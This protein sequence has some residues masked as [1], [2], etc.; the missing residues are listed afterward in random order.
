MKKIQTRIQNKRD[1]EINWLAASTF[2]PLAGELIIYSKEVDANGNILKTKR[3]DT[4]ISVVPSSGAHAR[5]FAYTYDRFKIGNGVDFVGDLAFVN[6][7]IEI[8]T[9]N[10]L[11]TSGT[12]DPSTAVTSKYY[13]KYSE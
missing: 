12:A 5:S 8:T 7:T 3:G 10:N 1:F 11:I 4:E 9:Q 2:Q 6:D 13:F